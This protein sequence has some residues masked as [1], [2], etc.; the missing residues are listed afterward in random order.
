MAD[1][2]QDRAYG[3]GGHGRGADPYGT[4]RDD[5]DPLAELARL[6]GQTDPLGNL[7]KGAPPV[8][9][10]PAPRQEVRQDYY[11]DEPAPEAED[12]P[13]APPLGPPAWMQRANIRR[14]APRVQPR[15]QQPT[16]MPRE[17]PRDFQRQMPRESLPEPQPQSDA[18]HA[19]YLNPVHPLHR[20]APPPPPQ[21]QADSYYRQ[22]YQQQPAYQHDPRAYAEPAQEQDHGQDSDPSRYDDALYGQLENGV[23]DFQREPAYPDDPYAYQGEYD[24]EIEEPVQKRRGPGL[25]VIGILALAVFGLG[26]AYGYHSYFGT[27]RT[28]EPPVIK[29]DNSPTKIV[30]AQSDANAKVPDRIAS[31]DGSEKMVPRE[32]QPVDVNS[33]NVGPRVVFPPLNQNANPPSV[34]SVT[35]TAMPPAPPPGAGPAAV[36]NG[37]MPSSE[38]HKVKIVSVKGDQPD[39]SA[40]PVNAPPPAAPAKNAKGARNPNQANASANGPLSLSPQGQSAPAPEAQ[41]ATT[42]PAQ[43]A[44]SAPASSGGYLVSIL[45]QPSEAEARAAF[46][47]MQGKYPS[48]LG[49][50]SPVIARANSK[51]GGV[52][53]RAGV[54]FGT[55]A[56]ASQFCKS[57]ESAGGQCWVVKN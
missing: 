10:R 56:E 5:S 32:E 42:T 33:R 54:S 19:D 52:M 1:R 44:P 23:Q 43:I 49:S 38:P 29:A 46:R 24:E 18:E 13:P 57:Y 45:S 26:A 51:S 50:Q 14:D 41:V 3:A 39:P 17:T 31:S 53:Y 48:V 22:D 40:M 8:Q 7:S 47:S 15:D 36:N 11:Q 6:I 9:P 21:P 37:T 28:G 12:E 34:A 4:D 2:Y 16:E 27:V 35:P 30:P 20:Y 25:T 55:Q